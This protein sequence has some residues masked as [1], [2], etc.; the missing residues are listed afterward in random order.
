MFSD[1]DLRQLEGDTNAAGFLGEIVN[2]GSTL[3]IPNQ[4]PFKSKSK[5]EE[6]NNRRKKHDTP[7]PVASRNETFIVTHCTHL[8]RFLRG[9][10]DF[11][12]RTGIWCDPEARKQRQIAQL[13][14][15]S[16]GSSRVS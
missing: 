8:V 16:W 2:G 12:S 3:A 1:V 5:Q 14:R 6:P 10:E 13:P 9:C 15:H 7:V 4:K 11:L